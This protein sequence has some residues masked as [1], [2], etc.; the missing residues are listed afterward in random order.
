M[1]S[2]WDEAWLMK[3]HMDTSHPPI[4][5]EGPEGGA[6]QMFLCDFCKVEFIVH[7]GQ[8]QRTGPLNPQDEWK[9]RKVKP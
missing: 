2:S 1:I 8:A 4:W 5:R 6:S 9:Y 3:A 7:P